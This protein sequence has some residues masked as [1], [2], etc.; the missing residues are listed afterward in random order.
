MQH[1]RVDVGDVMPGSPRVG[2]VSNLSEL[3]LR[4]CEENLRTGRIPVLRQIQTG[5]SSRAG[6]EFFRF[7]PQALQH[8]NIQVRSRRWVLQIEC[9]VLAM[10]ESSAG[11]QPRQIL[12]GMRAGISQVAAE[13]HHR[14]VEQAFPL[15]FCALQ[16]LQELRR[17]QL[18]PVPQTSPSAPARR[19]IEKRQ[20][21]RVRKGGASLSEAFLPT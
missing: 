1:G 7:N 19:S 17:D 14:P 2:Q 11:K 13:E 16:V 3:L 20:P 6:S 21:I 15:F 18:W 10:S 5:Q 4:I 8:R 12:R 9:Q